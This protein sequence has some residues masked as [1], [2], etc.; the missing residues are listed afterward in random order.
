MANFSFEGFAGHSIRLSIALSQSHTNFDYTIEL[1]KGEEILATEEMR[2]DSTAEMKVFLDT[3]I[4]DWNE[5]NPANKKPD[6]LRDITAIERD[7]GKAYTNTDVY[8]TYGITKSKEGKFTIWRDS[9]GNEITR[10]SGSLR[11]AL[12]VGWLITCGL[13]DGR[14]LDTQPS[15]LFK[16]FAALEIGTKFQL[17]FPGTAF[18]AIL[19]CIKSDDDQYDTVINDQTKTLEFNHGWT[20][21]S[22]HTGMLFDTSDLTSESLRQDLEETGHVNYE[23][24]SKDGCHL[25]ALDVEENQNYL[26]C[27]IEHR[28]QNGN[29]LNDISEHRFVS[30]CY[31][32]MVAK[33]KQFVLDL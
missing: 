24:E 29:V 9:K 3:C 10:V 1:F 2:A 8:K 32:A 13:L 26:D 30:H 19:D 14:T 20:N 15:E 5:N 6:A 28:D 21:G 25:I 31:S 16:Q 22:I 11:S 27:Y 12:N 18:N 4:R 33:L 23:F 17:V 7:K